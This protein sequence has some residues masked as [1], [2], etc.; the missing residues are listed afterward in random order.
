MSRREAIGIKKRWWR[1]AEERV[2]G[3]L[4]V[5][6]VE[7][8]VAR[9]GNGGAEAVEIVAAVECR[10]SFAIVAVVRVVN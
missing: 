3:A 4:A 9:S 10:G 1:G 6:V 7:R 8:K 2:G 5:V